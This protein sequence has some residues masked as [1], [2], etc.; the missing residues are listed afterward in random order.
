[1]SNLK[2]K[3]KD[4]ILSSLINRFS[5]STLCKNI[6]TESEL[7]A[8]NHVKNGFL[9]ENGWWNSW[10]NK[11]PLDENGKPLPWVTYSF[12]NF[13]SDRLNNKMTVFEFGSGNSTQFYSQKVKWIDTVEHD[14]DWFNKV[15][16]NL[17]ENVS[18][19]NKTLEY[20]GVYSKAAL[21]SKKKYDLIIID[22]RDRVNSL[23]NSIDA[24]SLNGVLVLDDSERKTY[25]KGVDYL[26]NSG[27]KKIDFW[28][29][30][31]GLFY[32][33]CTSIYYKNNN[34]LNI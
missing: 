34:V 27:F 4:F 30:S 1:M 22:G 28:G 31:P 21:D 9:N 33:K 15:K 26:L 19:S 24:L 18:I 25:Q 11:E 12:I 8:L 3:V 5:K 10:K 7:E 29:V 20:G 14:P 6:L 17:P 2:L 16:E 23:I 13:I 32:N